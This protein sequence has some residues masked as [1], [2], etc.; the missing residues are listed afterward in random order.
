M[1]QGPG[2]PLLLLIVQTG[3]DP[4][5]VLG[6]TQTHLYGAEPVPRPQP[7]APEVRE[8]VHTFPQIHLRRKGGRQCAVFPGNPGQ[9]P[10]VQTPEPLPTLGTMAQRVG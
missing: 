1:Q 5:R 8:G 3:G 2:S 4:E 9:P 10:L 6:A 7:P